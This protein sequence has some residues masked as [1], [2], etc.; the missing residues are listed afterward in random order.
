MGRDGMS[1]GQTGGT[2][3]WKSTKSSVKP[4]WKR[5]EVMMIEMKEGT[6][7]E[8]QSEMDGREGK[9]NICRESTLHSDLPSWICL[10]LPEV[11]I[12]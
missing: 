6:K 5:R 2:P 9:S 3:K 11:S 8:T 10:S 4:D 1:N 12:E 7:G